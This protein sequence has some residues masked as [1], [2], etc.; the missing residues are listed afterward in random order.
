MQDALR[1]N[2]NYDET[3]YATASKTR[4]AFTTGKQGDT[5]RSMNV[6]IDHLDTLQEASTALKNGQLPV[7]NRI[8]NEYAKQTG[9][10]APT[11]FEGIKA[12]VGDELVKAIVGSGAGALGD[13]EEM[14][15]KIDAA[16]TPQQ[17]TGVINEYQKLMAGQVKGLKIQYE[18]AGLKDFDNKLAPRTKKILLGSNE[19]T[20]TRSNW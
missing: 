7:F 2:P 6:A 1:I 5:V 17:L 8:A 20:N 19:S 15:K 12:I 3:K 14:K 10:T 13:R 4:Q 11:N 9:Q 18:D 16:L